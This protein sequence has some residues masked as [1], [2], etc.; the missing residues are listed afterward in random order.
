VEQVPAK[1]K[2]TQTVRAGRST[3]AGRRT[4]QDTAA[5]GGRASA[6]H[7]GSGVT[8]IRQLA[9]TIGVSAPAVLKWFEHPTWTFGRGPWSGQQVA[10]IRQWRAR[11]LQPDPAR[12]LGGSPAL[13]DLGP[14]RRA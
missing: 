8:S 14:E 7:S 6:T 5:A 13:G 4:R 3:S 9:A 1:R 10:E 11:T 12:D 2:T